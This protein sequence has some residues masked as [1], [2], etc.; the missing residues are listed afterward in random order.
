MFSTRYVAKLELLVL[1]TPKVSK[2]RY[3]WLFLTE[4]TPLDDNGGPKKT[5]DVKPD[6]YLP[7]IVRESENKPEPPEVLRYKLVIVGDGSVGKTC[8]LM[9]VAMHPELLQ[10]TPKMLTSSKRLL[11][12]H[13]SR[14]RAVLPCSFQRYVR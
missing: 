12:R 8:L 5:T 13:I 6:W 1:G 2:P 10:G 14:G 4:K 3:L 9:L 11:Q 7:Q